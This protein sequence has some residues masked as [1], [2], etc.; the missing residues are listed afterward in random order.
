MLVDLWQKGYLKDHAAYKIGG[1]TQHLLF[2]QNSQQLQAILKE[3]T[4][5]NQ[6]F[7]IFGLGTN[8]LFN[9]YPQPD[10]VYISLKK[11]LNYQFDSQGLTLSAGI[12]LAFLA[13]LGLIIEDENLQNAHLLPGCIGAGAF[14][15]AKCFNWEMS[16]IL[17]EISFYDLEDL[18]AG[19]KTIKASECDFA[20]KKS[21]FQTKPYV[22]TDLSLSLQPRVLARFAAEIKAVLDRIITSDLNFSDLKTF[23]DFFQKLAIDLANKNLPPTIK[24]VYDYR[25]EK[26]H[27]DY[28]SCGSVF[29]NNYQYGVATGKLVEDL[30]LKGK[31]IG[32][33]QISPNHGNIIINLGQG[34]SREVELLIAE[35]SQQIEHVYGFQ[36]DLEVIIVS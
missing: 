21:L 12:P 14:I 26:L 22:I 1:F 20:Y 4:K 2:P 9:D 6:P 31:K 29:K 25:L 28:P 16:D 19:K 24:K 30:G 27:F 18:E 17:A 10:K 36:P 15:N 23:A 35:I 5:K 7:F 3:L 32:E 13:L 11:M 33:V 34:T 8:L